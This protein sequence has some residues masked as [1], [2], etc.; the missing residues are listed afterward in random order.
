LKNV[1]TF[2]VKSGK[3][4]KAYGTSGLIGF[5]KDFINNGKS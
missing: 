4:S 2:V 1:K 3:K 5:L